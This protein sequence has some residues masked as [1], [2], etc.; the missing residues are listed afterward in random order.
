VENEFGAINHTYTLDVV[1]QYHAQKHTVREQTAPVRLMK[2]KLGDEGR[3]RWSWKSSH[4]ENS[5]CVCVCVWV[6]VWVCVGCSIAQVHN[7]CRCRSRSAAKCM[8][9]SVNSF[10]VI[11]INFYNNLLFLLDPSLTMVLC[12]LSYSP[13]VFMRGCI[14]PNN[15][16]C[17]KLLK[18]LCGW[19]LTTPGCDGYIR[20]SVFTTFFVLHAN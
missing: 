9:A 17:C 7:G 20:L 6:W 4:S 15:N 2:E 10:D 3:G 1:G 19:G 5:V 12:V 11:F 8:E 18:S 13:I 16:Q 14:W